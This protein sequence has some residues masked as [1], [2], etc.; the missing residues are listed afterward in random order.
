MKTIC[1]IGLSSLLVM[2]GFP[3]SIYFI[4]SSGN[5][6]Y[7]GTSID[8]SF[9]TLQHAADIAEP[10]DSFYVSAGNYSGF[11]IRT[12]GTPELP[13]VFK[14]LE[15]NVVIDFHNSRTNDGIN[16][17]NVSWIVIDGFNVIDQPRA[18]IRA[19]VSDF[20]II[21]NNYCDNNGKWGIFTGFTDDILIENNICSNSNDE[22]GIY[23]SNSSD[24]PIV[25]N[26]HCFGNNG[27]GLHFNGDFSM[28]GDGIISNAVIEGNIIHD[29]GNAGGSA[30][31]MDGVQNSLILNNLIYK[32][33]ST[34]IA[35]YMIDAAEGSKNNKVFN[36]TIINPSDARWGILC[37]N[38]SAGNILY[39]NIIINYHSFRGSIAV[40]EAS[41]EN[42]ISDY[43]IV[44]D[45]LS[46]D[47]G[48][49]NMGLEEWQD[50]GYDLHSETAMPEN[51]IFSDYLSNDYSIKEF[52]QAYNKGT[53]L[54]NPF[55]S[56][57]INDIP[58]PQNGAFDIGAY[59]YYNPAGA[60]IKKLPSRYSLS[61][62]Y[63]NPFNPS[64]K[65]RYS[66]D[67]TAVVQIT[68]YDFLGRKV[69]SLVNE[70]KHAGIHEIE[71]N[72]SGLSSGVYLYELRAGGFN[73]TKKLILLK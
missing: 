15:E 1:M 43:N 62:N 13:I 65:I 14:A 45:R 32:N 68:L 56:E 47:D 49:S 23:V 35:M 60:G 67:H 18:G 38:G 57:D 40:D 30:I 33:H 3:Q 9:Q 12:S 44:V 39:N 31:N 42:F 58:R 8:S 22:H 48:N 52:S 20:I 25:R 50:L 29:N 28:G 10:G 6:S 59:E 19:A 26:N 41:R 54:V 7:P 17:E 21:K 24:R 61:Q 37:V 51:E 46:A 66:M 69:A 36:N 70:Q 16:I 5:D 73:S 71:F 27:C 4:S 2:T 63:P 53:D 55:L 64:T 34:G 72:A 11:D